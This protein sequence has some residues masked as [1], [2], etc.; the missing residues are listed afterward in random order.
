MLSRHYESTEV[1]R[2][3]WLQMPSGTHWSTSSDSQQVVE[4]QIE[5]LKTFCPRSQRQRRR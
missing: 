2:K 5:T 3:T 1:D 4:I